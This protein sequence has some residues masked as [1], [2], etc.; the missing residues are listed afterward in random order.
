M[1]FILPLKTRTFNLLILSLF[2]SGLQLNFAQ[3]ITISPEPQWRVPVK[4]SAFKVANRSVRDGYYE[5]LIEAQQHVEQ[6]TIY[7][8]EIREIISNEGVQNGSQIAVSFD[9][10][11]EKIE[12]HKVIVKRKQQSIKRFQI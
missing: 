11:Y 4:I 10:S 9:P 7:Y 2:V 1:L 6:Q 5:K 3:K 8:H 12:F